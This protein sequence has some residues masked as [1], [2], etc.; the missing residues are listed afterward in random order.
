M[1]NACLTSKGG[2]S[3]NGA[4]ARTG[5]RLGNLCQP[6]TGPVLYGLWRVLI[7][8]LYLVADA[9]GLFVAWLI[10]IG[11]TIVMTKSAM[12]AVSLWEQ[13]GVL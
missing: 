1:R 9:A 12:A 7:C 8:A 13:I 2:R 11:F 5:T 6:C 10:L 4:A 3:F